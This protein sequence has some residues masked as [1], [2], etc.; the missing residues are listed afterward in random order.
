MQLVVT[1]NFAGRLWSCLWRCVWGGY[2]LKRISSLWVLCVQVWDEQQSHLS[3]GSGRHLVVPHIW[4]RSRGQRE[5]ESGHVNIITLSHT[6]CTFNIHQLV[7]GPLE[8][9]LRS[10][11]IYCTNTVFKHGE[12]WS[13]ESSSSVPSVSTRQQIWRHGLILNVWQFGFV[14]DLK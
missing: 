2:Y 12:M 14:S 6:P 8:Q 10:V 5:K 9:T 3:H 4:G 1:E 11:N 7:L 13:Q